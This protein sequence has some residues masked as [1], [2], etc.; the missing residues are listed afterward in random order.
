MN[1]VKTYW[2]HE[3][4]SVPYQMGSQK[5][6]VYILNKLKELNVT[7]LLDVGCGTGPIFELITNQDDTFAP[8]DNIIAYKGVDYSWRMIE[9]CKKLFP[10][11]EFAVGDARHLDDPDSSW[12]AVL[13]MHCLDHLDDYAAA[14]KEAVR[15]AKKYI[16][17]CLWRSFVNEGTNLNNRNTYGLTDANGELLPGK[18]PWEDTHLQDYSKEVLITEFDKYGLIDVDFCDSEEVNDPGRFNTVWILK[19]P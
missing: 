8:W 14:I 1:D 9:T 5:H 16:I 15:V 6:R 12:E 19:K 2:E 11:G 18:E 13:L 4:F 3:D 10:Y 17:I 7:T